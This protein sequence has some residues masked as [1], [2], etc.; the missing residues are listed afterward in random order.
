M[1]LRDRAVGR[2]IVIGPQSQ[3][4]GPEPSVVIEAPP[5]FAWDEKKWDWQEING[6][7]QLVGQYRALHRR[8]GQWREFDGRLDQTRRQI[9]TYIA[10]PPP[11]VRDHPHGR[12]LQLVEPGWF[13]LHWERNPNTFDDALLYMERLLDEAINHRWR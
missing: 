7:R 13:R 1:N 9:A 10:D 5:R 6:R 3:I 2:S 8:S 4:I 12:C 11:E